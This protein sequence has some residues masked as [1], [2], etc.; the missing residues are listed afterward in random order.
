MSVSQAS[1]SGLWRLAR[2]V[3]RRR[4][5]A[6]C[7]SSTRSFFLHD[8]SHRQ[9]AKFFAHAHQLIHHALKLAHGLNLPSI[10]R[11]QGGVSQAHGDRFLSFLA[12]EQ[13]IRTAFDLGTVSM[14]DGEEL[15]GQ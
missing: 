4:T 8:L 15:F 14:F 11:D 1:K 6:L 2:A 13:R 5:S 9:V 10:E 12:S 3:A 7:S